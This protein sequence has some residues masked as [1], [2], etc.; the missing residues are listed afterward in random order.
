MAKQNIDAYADEGG[1]P[2]VKKKAKKIDAVRV[3]I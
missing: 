2:S 1:A 3:P